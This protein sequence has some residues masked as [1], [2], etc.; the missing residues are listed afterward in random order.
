MM[1]RVLHADELGSIIGGLTPQAREFGVKL[2]VTALLSTVAIGVA[3]GIGFTTA[4]FADRVRRE[5]ERD[6][7]PTAGFAAPA[8]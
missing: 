8:P 7:P 1:A 6:S 5:K 3:A 4:R 2:G